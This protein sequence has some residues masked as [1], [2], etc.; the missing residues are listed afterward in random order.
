MYDLFEDRSERALMEHCGYGET[1][2]H[3]KHCKCGCNIVKDIDIYDIFTFKDDTGKEKFFLV[4]DQK[5][6]KFVGD[7]WHGYIDGIDLDSYYPERINQLSVDYTVFSLDNPNYSKFKNRAWVKKND[8]GSLVLHFDNYQTSNLRKVG[9][10]SE[11][12]ISRLENIREVCSYYEYRKLIH[13]DINNI[14]I[15]SVYVSDDEPHIYQVFGRRGNDFLIF[16]TL[17]KQ[18]RK[19]DTY[20]IP[21]K[22]MN[23]LIKSRSLSYIG[24]IHYNHWLKFVNFV[25]SRDD[26]LPEGQDKDFENWIILE[27]GK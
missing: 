15:G 18:T 3:D 7:S 8:D 11:D 17:D 23:K 20:T 6:N 26:D 21:M 16:I 2:H 19:V 5:T 1:H 25:Y 9:L 12:E 10:L 4:T 24:Y 14:C 27:E 22:L 13:E